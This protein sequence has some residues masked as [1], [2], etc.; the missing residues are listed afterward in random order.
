MYSACSNNSSTNDKITDVNSA[1]SQ[2]NLNSDTLPLTN[3]IRIFEYNNTY[4]DSLLICEQWFSGTVLVKK[5]GEFANRIPIQS[6]FVSDY[7]ISCA[8]GKMV[9]ETF[10]SLMCE[11]GGYSAWNKYVFKYDSIKRP[12]NVKHFKAWY[13]SVDKQGNFYTNKK[14]K[15][16]MGEEISFG[17][18]KLEVIQIAKNNSGKIIEKIIKRT[19]NQSRLTFQQWDAGNEYRYRLYNYFL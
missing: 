18:N 6:D 16:F 4:S 19:D 5:I 1:K 13:E 14:P 8:N 11:L 10:D 12:T 17:Y 3:Y 15:Y 7:I 2:H 9:Y